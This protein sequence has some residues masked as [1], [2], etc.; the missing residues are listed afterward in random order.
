MQFLIEGAAQLQNDGVLIR[1]RLIQPRKDA[2][3]WAESY[4]RDL[5][6]SFSVQ[7][8]ERSVALDPDFAEG[9]IPTSLGVTSTMVSPVV[10]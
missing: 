7:F 9:S 4:T 5:S 8:L 10:K 6:N 2:H 3:L 1:A